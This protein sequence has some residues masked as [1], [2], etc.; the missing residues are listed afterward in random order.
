M[1]AGHDLD[2]VIDVFYQG[3]FRDLEIELVDCVALQ[4]LV[5]TL[6]EPGLPKL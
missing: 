5:D 6:A 1:H 2:C 3:A 4:G